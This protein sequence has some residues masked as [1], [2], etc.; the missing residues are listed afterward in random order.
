[1][2]KNTVQIIKSF[3]FISPIVFMLLFGITPCVLG[4]DLKTI[5]ITQIV[6]HSSLNKVHAG[7]I[8]QLKNH[9]I[10]IESY[11]ANG[12]IIT[13]SQ[14]A[15][16]II[17][18]NPDLIIAIATPSAQTVIKA[19]RNT[20]IPVLFSTVTD[21]VGSGLVDNLQSPGKNV[22]GVRNLSPIKEQL[23]MIKDFMPNIKTVGMIVNYSDPSS[24]F[25]AKICQK[26]AKK[27]AIELKIKSIANS[28]EVLSAAE[29]LA[30]KVD[31]IFLLQDNTV[32]SANST[33]VK[34]SRDYKIPLFASY[35][36]VTESGALASLSYDEY[37]IGQETAKMAL[38]VLNGTKVGS[39]PVQDPDHFELTINVEIAKQLNIKIPNG[40]NKNYQITYLGNIQKP[41]L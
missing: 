5:A 4:S 25:L 21:P 41:R 35:K 24:N 28:S 26:E 6:S 27:L 16:K 1:M 34:I 13:A 17:N 12:S 32:A 37:E 18:Q 10:K 2:L 15:N 33:L 7:I 8:N 38:S 29:S 11:N 9:D 20:N 40:F 36:E 3:S 22:S 19:A 30:R 39:I 31:A 14:I 23:E